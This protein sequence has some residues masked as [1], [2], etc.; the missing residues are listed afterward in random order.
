MGASYGVRYGR[1]KGKK[2][3]DGETARSD[4]DKK[5][6]TSDREKERKGETGK[7]LG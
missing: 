1:K 4:Y 3:D 5:L 6:G 7:F 2:M